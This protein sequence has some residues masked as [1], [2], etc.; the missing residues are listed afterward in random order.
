MK[1]TEKQK[2]GST[3]REWNRCDDEHTD[4]NKLPVWWKCHDSLIN[5]N[6]FMLERTK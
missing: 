2:K 6:I 1:H 3:L 4:E 5:V